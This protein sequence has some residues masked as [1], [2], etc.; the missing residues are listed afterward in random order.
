VNGNSKANRL[1]TFLSSAPDSL[2]GRVLRALWEY[3]DVIGT[4]PA[5]GDR[6]RHRVPQLVMCLRSACIALDRRVHAH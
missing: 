5:N 6:D 4:G 1:R 3:R 2:A